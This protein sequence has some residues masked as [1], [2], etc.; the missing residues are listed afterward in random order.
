M[1]AYSTS[2]ISS[3]DTSVSEMVK[4]L[5]EELHRGKGETTVLYSL[6][7]LGLVVMG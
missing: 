3:Y 5:Y 2:L 7:K 1:L 6:S 4:A